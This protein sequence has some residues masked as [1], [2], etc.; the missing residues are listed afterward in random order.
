MFISPHFIPHQNL[1]EHYIDSMRDR[2]ASHLTPVKIKLINWLIKVEIHEFHSTWNTCCDITRLNIYI[3]PRLWSN[4]VVI[5]DLNK[6]YRNIPSQSRIESKSPNSKCRNW[7]LSILLT[8]YNRYCV[9]KPFSFKIK[10]I[11]PKIINR[12]GMPKNTP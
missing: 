7:G 9:I 3:E 5:H 2:V 10:K 1:S 12:A 8:I 6:G 11:M 4:N